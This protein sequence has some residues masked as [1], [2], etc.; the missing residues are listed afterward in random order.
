MFRNKF[1]LSVSL[2]IVVSCLKFLIFSDSKKDCVELII[3]HNPILQT[4]RNTFE[5]V[6]NLCR[7]DLSYNNLKF[8]DHNWMNWS[9]LHHGADFQGNPIDC[10]CSS[11]WILDYFVPMMYENP[12]NHHYLYDLRCASPERFKNHRLVRYFN[13]SGAFCRT[14]VKLNNNF[15]Y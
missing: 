14:E 7:L 1:N 2:C 10:T 9:A 11:Q 12:K 13:H 5:R 3:T 6:L 4:I 8:I 15:F